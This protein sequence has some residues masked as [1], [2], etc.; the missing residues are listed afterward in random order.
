M[1]SKYADPKSFFSNQTGVVDLKLRIG[2][3]ARPYINFGYPSVPWYRGDRMADE[4]RG[5]YVYVAAM[6]DALPDL[7]GYSD[8]PFTVHVS[9]R[10]RDYVVDKVVVVQP[11]VWNVELAEFLIRWAR[12][13][14]Q[15]RLPSGPLPVATISF[16]HSKLGPSQNELRHLA[17]IYAVE[18]DP[19]ANP[20]PAVNP[21]FSI[22]LGFAA[23]LLWIDDVDR[24]AIF[25][26]YVEEKDTPFGRW[27]PT[28]F[29]V[30]Y[31]HCCGRPP[32]VE[33]IRE[34]FADAI[35][36]LY[37]PPFPSLPGGRLYEIG[38]ASETLPKYWNT[39]KWSDKEALVALKAYRG[40]LYWA[41]NNYS[42]PD[43]PMEKDVRLDAEKKVRVLDDALRTETKGFIGHLYRGS[44]YS[45]P[46]TATDTG[47]RFTSATTSI[48]IAM[49]FA[50]GRGTSMGERVRPKP[51]DGFI[52]NVGGLQ[53]IIVEAATPMVRGNVGEQELVFPQH[54]RLKFQ[55]YKLTV[56]DSH[57]L[58]DYDQNGLMQS[59]EGHPRLIFLTR[60]YRFIGLIEMSYKRARVQAC[61][62]C[63][64]PATRRCSGCKQA[65]Y[66][67]DAQCAA[68]IEA[69]LDKCSN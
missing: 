14:D 34:R 58:K 62:S 18:G 39:H 17:D 30:A 42:N 8:R 19:G 29:L 10:L 40:E 48:F 28:A 46:E 49:V 25:A 12:Q 55:K 69:H 16:S 15:T 7:I 33:D 61:I 43:A 31:M 23:Y 65:H 47:E 32:E 63:A 4:Q 38:H 57:L 67:S 44:T 1:Q 51:A 24:A 52:P 68:H 3:D 41:M 53:E 59:L 5:V 56:I 9:A 27:N 37:P 26:K 35:S 2:P 13:A 22:K 20:D 21:L 60:V 36:V 6:A 64:Q 11:R 45:W 54:V 66:C 50:L